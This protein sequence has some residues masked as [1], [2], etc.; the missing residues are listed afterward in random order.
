M[1]II[2]FDLS[3]FFNR[4]SYVFLATQYDCQM[5]TKETFLRCIRNGWILL[6]PIITPCWQF[7]I[8]CCLYTKQDDLFQQCKHCH[9]FCIFT[10]IN[11]WV[12]YL[13]INRGGWYLFEIPFIYSDFIFPFPFLP[14]FELYTI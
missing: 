14:L 10:N 13:F 4:F 5:I 12:Y 11:S 8:C 3:F 6:A 1:L 7:N 2:S 9:L